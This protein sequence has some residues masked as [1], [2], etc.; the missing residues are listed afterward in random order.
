MPHIRLNGLR[1]GSRKWLPG[2][3]RY[4][5]PDKKLF[6][7]NEEEAFLASMRGGTAV[8]PSS[9]ARIYSLAAEDF[10]FLL[11]A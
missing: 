5:D 11:K 1:R 9:A 10:L 2:F 3:H 4:Q 6:H 7:P 8:N